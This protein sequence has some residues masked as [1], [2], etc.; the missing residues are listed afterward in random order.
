MDKKISLKKKVLNW[1]DENGYPLE[2]R[3]ASLLRCSKKNETKFDE[4]PGMEGSYIRQ[5]SHYQDPE[6]NS[7]REIDLIWSHG[8][9]ISGASIDFVIECKNTQK[10]WILFTSPEAGSNFNRI[11]AF[12]I[13]SKKAKESLFESLGSNGD[14]A[15]KRIPWLWKEGGQIGYGITQA[16]EGNQDAP[17]KAILSAVKASLWLENDASKKTYSASTC[18]VAFPV[19]V[20]SSPLFECFLDESGKTVLKEIESGFLFFNQHIGTF[21]AVCVRVLTQSGLNNFANECQ[22]IVKELMAVFPQDNK[23]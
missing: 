12:G 14:E 7:S 13:L 2:M 17:Y 5:G 19:V 23:L 1:L 15:W 11:F 6:T 8:N 20:T 9:F 21:Q 22:S 4:A 18:F 10:P 3:V 16:F